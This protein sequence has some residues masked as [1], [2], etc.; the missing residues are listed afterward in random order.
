MEPSAKRDSA[1]SGFANGYA[2]QD[3]ETS[4][5]WANDISDPNLRVSTLTRAGQAYFRRDPEAAKTWLASSG[6]SAEVQQAIQNPP[7]RRR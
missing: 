4:I 6:L 5:A 1:I 3:P 2:Y 7:R